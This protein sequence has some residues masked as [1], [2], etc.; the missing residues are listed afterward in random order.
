M[1]TPLMTTPKP[2]APALLLELQAPL[3]GLAWVL[4]HVGL[5]WLG[6]TMGHP[7]VCAVAA[8]ALDGTILSMIAVERA[9]ES[10][11]AGMTGLLSGLSLDNLAGGQTLITKL[12]EA[13]HGVVDGVLESLGG[14][15][16]EATHKVIEGAA[17]EAIWVAITVVLAALIVKCINTSS[18]SSRNTM[19][20]SHL[21]TIG[22][23]ARRGCA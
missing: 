5:G 21:G 11:Q 16:D 7:N 1:A 18:R 20:P 8:G 23:R 14:I 19:L 13:I 4:F 15:G 6:L 12:A 22:G 10:F 17:V 2:A 9:S 3:L